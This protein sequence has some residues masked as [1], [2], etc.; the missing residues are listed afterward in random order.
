MCKS[1]ISDFLQIVPVDGLWIDMNEPS[2][3]C[4]GECKNVLTGATKVFIKNTTKPLSPSSARAP[5]LT[6]PPY[7]INNQGNEAPLN[8]KTVDPDA[9]Q[10]GTTHY[11]A[12]NLFGRLPW[13]SILNSWHNSIVGS[14][15]SENDHGHADHHHA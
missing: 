5:T 11:N 1:Q 15:S 10:D 12:H 14:G 6:D 9:L 2:N 7:S 8:T 4:N 3:F 13:L